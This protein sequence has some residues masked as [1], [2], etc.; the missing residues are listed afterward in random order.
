MKRDINLLRQLLIEIEEDTQWPAGKCI[1]AE[2][3]SKAYSLHLLIRTGLVEEMESI[4]MGGEPPQF[5]ISG[6]TWQGY[7][8]LSSLFDQGHWS[9]F[10]RFAG[11]GLS[12][13]PFPVIVKLLTG[14]IEQSAREALQSH[15]FMS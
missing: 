3:A 5:L 10:K 12:S 4:V 11:T 6:L 1:A 14:C 7:E 2:D 9:Q 8:F 15:G 13:I